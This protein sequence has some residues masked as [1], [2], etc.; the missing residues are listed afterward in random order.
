MGHLRGVKSAIFSGVKLFY[1]LPW[2]WLSRDHQGTLVFC[3]YPFSCSPP[4][5]PFLSPRTLLFCL[6]QSKN[7]QL[8]ARAWAMQSLQSTNHIV[9]MTSH[10][11]FKRHF[12]AQGTCSPYQNYFLFL[13]RLFVC[14]LAIGLL[15]SSPASSAIE[16]CLLSSFSYFSCPLINHKRSS[17]INC[18][19]NLTLNSM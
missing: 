13:L 18:L 10:C 19:I 1:F 5:K 16:W 15:L 11:D 6:L 9:W 2:L 8:Q 7:L 14:F 17:T 3:D 12:Y 4:L